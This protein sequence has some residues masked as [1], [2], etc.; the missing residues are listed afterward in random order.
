[1]TTSGNAT[2]QP[3]SGRLRVGI[4]GLDTS[5]VVAFTKVVNAAAA[6]RRSR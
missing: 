2:G 3:G 4:L 6:T 5:H 1:M